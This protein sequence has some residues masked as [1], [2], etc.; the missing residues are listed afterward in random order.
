MNK[1][2]I[3]RT[4]TVS[5]SM[6]FF[7]KGQ[8][9]FLSTYFDVLAASSD[10]DYIL[11]DFGRRENI[12][13]VS[14][15]MKRKISVVHDLG[16]LITLIRLFLKERPTIVHSMTPKSGLLSMLAAKIVG[17]PVRMHTF[18]GLIFPERTGLLRLLL[19]TM[20]RLLCWSATSGYPEGQGVLNDLRNYK[21][22]NK[23]LK[24]IA[25][26]NING[27]DLKYFHP[28]EVAQSTVVEWLVKLGIKERDFVWVYVGRLVG[29]KGINE[30]V[31]A[32]SELPFDS[33]LLLVGSYENDLDP[34]K[35][36]TLKLIADLD[37][38]ISVGFQEDIRPFL[39]MSSCF[40]FPSYR[41][42]FPNVVLQAGSFNLPCIVTDINGS[43][44]II[45]D[46]Q[47]GLIHESKDAEQLKNAM[48]RIFSDDS[49]RY[50]L[51]KNARELVVEKFS[52]EYVWEELFQEYNIQIEE[53]CNI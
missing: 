4:A 49:L 29:D 12:R 9:N 37:S 3:V 28:N 16:S 1:I 5:I 19:I 27:I 26:G 20:D 40:V 18:T 48:I 23:P 33:K 24:V 51:S 44:E 30:L 15:P 38:I 6:K 46:G 8:L 35:R 17:V 2:K 42:G 10:E 32:F 14:V 7:L 39:A 52:Q 47:N 13:T 11:E 50:R 45:I 34:L 36:E 21:I 41:E 53:L 31:S 22:T 43:N 25:N